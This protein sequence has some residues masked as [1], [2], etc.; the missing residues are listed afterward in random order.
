LPAGGP[1]TRSQKLALAVSVVSNLS[2][3]GFFKYFNFGLDNYNWLVTALGLASWHWDTALRVTLQLVIDAELIKLSKVPT[4]EEI[5][6][7][8]EALVV[9]EYR[10]KQ[11][12]EGELKT[13]TVRVAHWALLDGAATTPAS[14]KPGWSGRI[15]LETFEANPQRKS[16]FSSDTLDDNFAAVLYYDPAIGRA[17]SPCTS[18]SSAA[19]GGCD[20]REVRPPREAPST[21][22]V[23][24]CSGRAPF[25]GTCHLD[26]PLGFGPED[27]GAENAPVVYAA[28][29][30]EKAVLS[31]GR[32]FP[33]DH[34][35]IARRPLR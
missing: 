19:P 8:R 2:L 27:S 24:L 21:Q 10:V 30:G 16:L 17:W 31:G 6:P 18:S 28:A 12:V 35:C 3:L 11:V 5:S 7:Y 32:I 26:A 23:L 1:R 33:I 22:T 15:N 9:G 34:S 14:R 29:T 4:L 25:G 13:Q 20:R